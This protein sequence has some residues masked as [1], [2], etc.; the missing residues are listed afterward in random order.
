[1]NPR[2]LNE[3]EGLAFIIKMFPSDDP[4]NRNI[5]RWSKLEKKK[6]ND[7]ILLASPERQ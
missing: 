6:S 4:T 1:M 3:L 7:Q 5:P 2:I